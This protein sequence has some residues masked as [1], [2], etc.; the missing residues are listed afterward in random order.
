[1]SHYYSAYIINIISTRDDDEV[2][3]GVG[4]WGVRRY[5]YTPTTKNHENSFVNH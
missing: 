5:L 1:M 4:H 3:A 2:G